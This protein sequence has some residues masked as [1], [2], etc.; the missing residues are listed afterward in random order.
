MPSADRTQVD[1]AI[2]SCK[3]NDACSAAWQAAYAYAADQ[4]YELAI[5]DSLQKVVFGGLQYSSA[6]R[7]ADLQ[8]DIADRQMSIAEEEY[9]R[10]KNNYVACEDALAAEICAME[11]VEVD[12]TIRADRAER[13]VR[14]KF[15]IARVKMESVRNRYCAHDMFTD[16]CDMGKEEALAL[17]MARDIAYR[18]A[19]TYRDLLDERRWARRVVI[20][21]HG[22][23]IMSGQSSAYDSGAGTASA[24]LQAKQDAYRDLTGALSGAFSTFTSA[25]TGYNLANN[26]QQQTARQ[27]YSTPSTYQSGVSMQSGIPMQ[28]GFAPLQ[29]PHS[30]RF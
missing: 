28:S 18:Y 29:V 23:N 2:S 5:F 14:K 20:L 11:C 16:L 13:D 25:R 8:Y 6:D 26:R 30:N 12:Y 10:Y 7:T 19:E 21:N 3:S 24:A 17:V 15:S 27:T 9:A 4:A 1:D 22:R